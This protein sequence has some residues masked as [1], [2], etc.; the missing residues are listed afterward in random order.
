MADE[1]QDTP[2]ASG[3]INIVKSPFGGSVLHTWPIVEAGPSTPSMNLVIRVC[4]NGKIYA[5]I[6][7]D[8]TNAFDE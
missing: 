5:G 7:Q 2:A 1:H 8:W 3:R 4:D 6:E